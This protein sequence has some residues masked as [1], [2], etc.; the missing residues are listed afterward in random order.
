MKYDSLN[1]EIITS[2]LIYNENDNDV[3]ANTLT[4]VFLSTVR[5]CRM[6]IKR[7]NRNGVIVLFSM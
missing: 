6:I 7:R 3:I 2:A 4:S 5:K 1:I